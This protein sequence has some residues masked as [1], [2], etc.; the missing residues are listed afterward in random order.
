MRQ[1]VPAELGDCCLVPSSDTVLQLVALALEPEACLPQSRHREDTDY[2]DAYA[3]KLHHA[4]Q[5]ALILIRRWLHQPGPTRVLASLPRRVDPT[6]APE[7]MSYT[8]VDDEDDQLRPL[9]IMAKRVALCDDIWHLL[10]KGLQNQDKPKSY[11]LDEL[12]EE[13][14]FG[15]PDSSWDLL[16]V[17]VKAWSLE[18]SYLLDGKLYYRIAMST[19]CTL[20]KKFDRC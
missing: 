10:S 2:E 7:R 11:T 19:R 5:K 6:Y 17:L 14:R 16:E 13:A 3:L 9:Q 1:F 15:L 8:F 18:S 20:L 12:A 4:S